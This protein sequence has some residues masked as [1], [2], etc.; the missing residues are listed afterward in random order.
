MT[1]AMSR[2]GTPSSSIPCNVDPAGALFDRQAEQSGR[3]EAVDGRPAVRA[4]ADVPGDAPGS[5]DGDERR[6]EP[7]VSVAVHRRGQSDDRRADAT[8][9]EGEHELGGGMAGLRPATERGGRRVERVPVAFGRR[10]SG[11]EPEDAG[12]DDERSVGAHQR[13]ADCL[14][15]GAVGVGRSLEVA[16]ERELVLEGE[17]EH[18][19]RVADRLA[20]DVQVVERAALHLGS[21]GGERVGRRVRAREP[22]HLMARADELGKNGRADPAGRSGHENPHGTSRSHVSYCRHPTPWMSATD[23][24]NYS[25]YMGRWQPESRGRLEQAALALYAERGFE[26]TTVAEIAERAGLTERT[27]FRHFADKRE[28]L[29]G[30]AVVLQELVVSA[31]AA[32]PE[33]AAPIDAVAGA[34][35]AAG[36]LLQ[37]RREFARKRHA[38]IAANAELRERELIKLATIAAA[39]ADALCARGAPR[40]AATL[41]AEAGIAVFRV[42]FERWVTESGKRTLQELM[43]ESM[44][45]LKAVTAGR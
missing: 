8:R 11:C 38:V 33:S 1:A 27:F 12:G 41:T 29:F 9:R 6:D 17:V 22:D 3:V 5:G 43:R 4:V 21:G 20:Q 30:G 39:L 18:A 24:R 42:A 35:D 40:P 16:R 7:G 37:E 44:D 45:E 15:R 23:I 31:A 25:R 26:N 13:L 36:A 34:L 28:V 10:L 2:T 32:A 19:V 14:D